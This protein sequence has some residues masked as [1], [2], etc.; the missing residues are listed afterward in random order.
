V[1]LLSA[2][3]DEDLVFYV[4]KALQS[5][6]Y[7]YNSAPDFYDIWDNFIDELH[8]SGKIDFYI[9]GLS[10]HRA[11]V[12]EFTLDYILAE[13]KVEYTDFRGEIHNS[14]QNVIMKEWL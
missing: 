12:D 2:Y 7:F 6:Y 9:D 10:I 8:I 11:K 3:D 1:I 4:I 13:L 5:C 14:A